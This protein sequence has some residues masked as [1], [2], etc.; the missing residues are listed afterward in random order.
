M[1]KAYR[2]NYLEVG[3]SHPHATPDMV[4]LRFPQRL[5]RFF[6]AGESSLQQ[7]PSQT[8]SPFD[9][10]LGSTFNISIISITAF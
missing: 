2:F 5:Q 9:P 8:A 7:A 10:S 1:S 6:T 4:N 3:Y